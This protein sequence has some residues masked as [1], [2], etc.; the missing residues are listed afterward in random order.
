MPLIPGLRRPLSSM[1][2]WS[3]KQVSGQLEL[4]H[5]ETC[6]KKKEREKRKERKKER[7]RKLKIKKSEL[8][9]LRSELVS[10]L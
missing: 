10:E 2:V 8:F 4:F 1:P 7:K 6:L 5:R 9:G 3:T